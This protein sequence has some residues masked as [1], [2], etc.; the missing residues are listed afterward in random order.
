MRTSS[1]DVICSSIIKEKI[2]TLS[3]VHTNNKNVF[4]FLLSF[5]GHSHSTLSIRNKLQAAII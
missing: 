1:G 3:T 4:P 2:N 5:F